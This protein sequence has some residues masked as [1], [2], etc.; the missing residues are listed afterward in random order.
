MLV[1]LAN[2]TLWGWGVN[3]YGMMGDASTST[4]RVPGQSGTATNWRQVSCGTEHALGTRT[5]GTLWAWGRNNNG[6]I[7]QGN[8]TTTQYT[9]PT[10]IGAETTWAWV[11]AGANHCVA[12]KTN[13]TLWAWGAH[14]NGQVGQGSTTTP[15]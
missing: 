4:R 2:G 3:T 14:G 5:D 6:Q 13:G 1:I 10:Q 7:G 8:T 9:S 15:I 12:V 11:V